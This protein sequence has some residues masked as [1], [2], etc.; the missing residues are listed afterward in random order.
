M[1]AFNIWRCADSGKLCLYVYSKATI[2]SHEYIN[3]HRWIRETNV[4]TWIHIFLLYQKRSSTSKENYPEKI[5][6]VQFMS[7]QGH[8]NVEHSS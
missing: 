5:Q 4:L 2:I 6:D 3:L 1:L 7:N 8:R